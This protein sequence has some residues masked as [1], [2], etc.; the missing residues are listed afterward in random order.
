MR[1][2]VFVLLAVIGVAGCAAPV[3]GSAR[4]PAGNVAAASAARIPDNLRGTEWRFIEIEGAAV[5]DSVVA[6]LR[7]ARKPRV[8][9]GGLQ[10][11]RRLVAG[12][13]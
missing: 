10:F 9:Q 8:G 11:V 4:D 1:Q 12:V 13:R 5:P 3:Q 6:T 2:A 7:L